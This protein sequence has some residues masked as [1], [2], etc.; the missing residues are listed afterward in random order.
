MAKPAIRPHIRLGALRRLVLPAVLL[1]LLLATIPAA[2]GDTIDINTATAEA[3]AAAMTGVGLRK[4]RAIVEYRDENGPFDSV[5]DLVKV[6]G[7][8]AATLESNRARLSVTEAGDA[9]AAPKSG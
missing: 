9:P 8:G 7:I 3:F 4:A 1:A 5:D 2:A 6:R